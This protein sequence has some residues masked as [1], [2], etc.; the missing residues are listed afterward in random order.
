MTNY[1]NEERIKAGVQLLELNHRLRN[2]VREYLAMESEPDIEQMKK[3]IVERGYLTTGF[4]ARCAYNG[5]YAV[6]PAGSGD[7]EVGTYMSGMWR[8]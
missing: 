6:I 1:I 7:L 5:V 8:D 3:D 2:L 4:T